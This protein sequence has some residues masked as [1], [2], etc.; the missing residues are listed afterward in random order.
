MAQIPC[1]RVV[2]SSDE[3]YCTPSLLHYL[4]LQPKQALYVA[5]GAVGSAIAL[6]LGRDFL[7]PLVIRLV[8]WFY[9]GT[10]GQDKV[11]EPPVSEAP[12]PVVNPRN[13]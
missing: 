10:G 3:L 6:Y 1:L 7:T 9:G 2:A 11:K 8:N 5:S 12:A 13:R 4:I